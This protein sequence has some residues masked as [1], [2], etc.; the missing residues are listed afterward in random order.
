M[1]S[2]KSVARKVRR[3]LIENAR[4]RRLAVEPRLADLTAPVGPTPE[5]PVRVR[6]AFYKASQRANSSRWFIGRPHQLAWAKRRGFPTADASIFRDFVFLCPKCL[7]GFHKWSEVIEHAKLAPSSDEGDEETTESGCDCH[8]L[9]NP[10]NHE[11][12]RY[13][14]ETQKQKRRR[15]KLPARLR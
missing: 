3:A 8:D 13:E 15:W 14:V 1:T 5:A 11:T 9:L 10:R 7:R 6:F 2:F 4:S 12:E